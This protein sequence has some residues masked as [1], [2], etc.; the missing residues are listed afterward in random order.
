MQQGVGNPVIT[1][2]L[3]SA[4]ET[5]GLQF[6]VFGSCSDIVPNNPTLTVAVKDGQNNTVASTTAANNQQNGT[7]EAN[8]SLPSTTNIQN[9][10]VVVT[11]SENAQASNGGLT[12]SGQGSLTITDPPPGAPQQV[13]GYAS[14]SGVIAKGQAR[15]G[16]GKGIWLRLTDAGNDI[17][18]HQFWW[19]PAVEG[20]WQ[21]DIGKLVIEKGLS[22][23]KGKHFNLHVSIWHHDS[24]RNTDREQVRVSSGFFSV[25]E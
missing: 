6:A 5:L 19:I 22:A 20:P 15:G 10:S 2:S 4:G 8:F 23:L 12:I 7:Y 18:G 3:P 13:A 17:I 9:G 14:W 25:G 24:E 1:I 11:C 21:C 16:N